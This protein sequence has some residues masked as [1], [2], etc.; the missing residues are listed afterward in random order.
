MALR[1]RV[2]GLGWPIQGLGESLGESQ[3]TQLPQPQSEVRWVEEGNVELAPSET[4]I[5]A[6]LP[7][8][9]QQSLAGFVYLRLEWRPMINKPPPF[10]GFDIRI[11]IISPIKG[12]GL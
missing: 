2:K 6:L 3:D 8:I 5:V 12:R 9:H 11:T 7:V 4:L 10:K 1:L